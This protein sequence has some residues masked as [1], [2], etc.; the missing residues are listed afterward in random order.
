MIGIRHYTVHEAEVSFHAGWRDGFPVAGPFGRHLAGGLIDQFRAGLAI[1]QVADAGA[2]AGG[3]FGEWRK[4]G[5]GMPGQDGWMVE[6]KLPLAAVEDGGAQ[7]S[8]WPEAGSPMVVCVRFLDAETGWWRMFQFHD[9]VLMPTE[10]AEEGENMF[11]TVAVSAGWMEERYHGA[12]VPALEPVVRGVIEWRHLGRRVRAWEYDDAEDA[13]TE[14]SENVNTVDAVAERYV[15]LTIAGEDELEEVDLSY[16]AALTQPLAKAGGV[17][18]YEVGW[19][20]AG[21]FH[22]DGSSGLTLWP[23]WVMEAEGAAEPLTMPPSGRHWEHP[24][25]VF[26]VLGRIYASLSHGVLAVPSFNEGFPEGMTD[27]PIR[28]GRLLLLPEGA[29]LLPE[30]WRDLV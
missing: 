14:G 23:G 20:D 2:D 4:H 6:M 28:L 18:G 10:A 5:C 22:V 29:W 19:M 21:A 11:R 17:P 25:V 7:V 9:A 1:R 27:M 24:K 15:T 16:M 8:S 13:F 26:R 3:A 12:A 30:N